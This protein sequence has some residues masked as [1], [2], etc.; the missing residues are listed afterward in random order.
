MSLKV[1]HQFPSFSNASRLHVVQ[2]FIRFQL[3]CPNR[4]VL[5]RQLVFLFLFTFY[6]YA[7]NNSYMYKPSVFWRCWLGGRKG[8]WPV[9]KYGVM[10]CWRGYLSGVRCKWFAYG[11]ADAIATPSSLTTTILRSFV[12]DYPGESVP[13]GHTILDFAEAAMI[14]WQWHQLNHVQATCTLLQK[15]TTSAPHQSDFYGWM[16]FLTRNQQRQSTEGGNE[17]Q[18]SAGVIFLC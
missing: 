3:A 10:R 4:A 14:A 12:R 17:E 9:K 18:W 16:P 13:E 5:Q 8:I 6:S 15:I 11:S 7:Y 2:H 1:V